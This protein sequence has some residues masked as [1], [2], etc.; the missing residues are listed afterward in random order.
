MKDFQGFPAVLAIV[1][2][3]LLLRHTGAGLLFF[4]V[5]VRYLE[6]SE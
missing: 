3:L 1:I 5:L 4:S 6:E 2:G